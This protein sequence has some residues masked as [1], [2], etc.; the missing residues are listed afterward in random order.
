M[1]T[2][3]SAEYAYHLHKAGFVS[4]EQT[5]YYLQGVCVEKAQTRP[6]C[7]LVATDGHRMGVFYDA[8]AH[9]DQSG[10]IVSLN[11]TGLA[12][13]KPGRHDMD[14]R[15]V[16][17]E[18]STVAIHDRTAGDAAA[19]APSPLA[20]NC[21]SV[22]DGTF[23]DWRRVVPFKPQTI[24]AHKSY[25]PAYLAAFNFKP[26][27]GATPALTIEQG[28][29]RDPAVVRNTAFPDFL[30][31]LMPMRAADPEK[32]PDIRPGW[33]NDNPHALPKSEAAE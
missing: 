24:H 7:Y 15:M 13:C 4:T 1:T 8:T 5:R 3:F 31:V 11:K 26:F 30:A 9:T 21:G 18:G 27:S 32:T 14:G 22:I 29:H 17:V 19:S 12:A 6:G 10:I 28:D 25:N 33:L 23:P 2:Y 20:I 16:V